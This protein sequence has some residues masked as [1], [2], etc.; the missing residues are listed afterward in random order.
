MIASTAAEAW[1]VTVAALPTAAT[2]SSNSPVCPGDD[3]VFTISGDAG[4]VVTYSGATSGTAIIGGSGTVAVTISGVTI[5]TTLN[6]TQ[7]SDGTCTR[8]LTESETVTVNPLPTAATLSSNSP[9]CPGDDAVFTISGNA[10]DV[11]TYSGSVMGTAIIEA[12]GTVDVTV[13]SVTTNTTLNLT[14]VSDGTC[15][16][17]LMV[18]EMVTVSAT[19][20]GGSVTADQTICSGSTPAQLSLSGQTGAVVRW[21]SS[22]DGGSNW[23]P[24]VNTNT[25]YDPPALTQT[26]QF[27]AVVQ[28]GVCPEAESSI[29]TVTVGDTEDPTASNPVPISVQC[30]SPAPDISVVDDEADNCTASPVVTFVSD[31]SDNMTCPETITRTYRV[32]DDCGN[33]IDVT[34]TITVDDTEDPTASNPDP[35]TVQCSGRCTSCGCKCG[36]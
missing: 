1:A 23:T 24:I 10:G 16:R 18:S 3:A 14:Q 11:V 5:P 29:V 33:F 34:Q 15:T 25:T 4:D 35:I 22:T 36:R 7:V 32:T 17:D 26:T 28:S 8:T 2:L 20:V 27:R 6:L 9:V 31:V 30:S 12:G 21:E 13:S 19:S